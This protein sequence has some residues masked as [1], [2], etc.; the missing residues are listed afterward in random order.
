MV[1]LWTVDACFLKRNAP[2]STLQCT[3]F[4]AAIPP[5]AN[6][7][8]Y[9]HRLNLLSEEKHVHLA[10]GYDAIAC[11]GKHAAKEVLSPVRHIKTRDTLLQGTTAEGARSSGARGSRGSRGLT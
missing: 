2:P 11:G 9:T 8:R 4:T 7:H 1:G 10:G 6:L 3:A 5:Q